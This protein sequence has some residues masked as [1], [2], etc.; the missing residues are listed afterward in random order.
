MG[1]SKILPFEMIEQNDHLEKGLPILDDMAYMFKIKDERILVLF[2]LERTRVENK[3]KRFDYSAVFTIE[4]GYDKAND[5]TTLLPKMST[6]FG[7]ILPN[8]LDV[9]NKQYKTPRSDIGLVYFYGI[10]DDD[11]GEDVSS[12]VE[13]KRTKLYTYFIN[14][15]TPP[16]FTSHKS[17][18]T[19]YYAKN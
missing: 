15:F 1:D 2:K 5:M 16:G 10:G 6:M 4:G 14:K 17:G 12:D 3:Q 8:F 9:F 11:K 19:L 7:G 18:N 13:T